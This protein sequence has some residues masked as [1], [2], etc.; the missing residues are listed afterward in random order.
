MTGEHVQVLQD[1]YDSE[2]NARIEWFFDAGFSV[3]LGDQMKGFIVTTQMP[4][5]LEAVYWLHAE[6]IKHYP[7]SAFAK[8]YRQ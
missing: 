1:L 8:K 2:I 5:F 4:T 3:S 6:A 7:D